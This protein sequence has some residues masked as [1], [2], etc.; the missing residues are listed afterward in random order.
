M[1][2]PDAETSLAARLLAGDRRALSRSLTV[3]ENNAA[4]SGPLLSE[5]FPWTGR[6]SVIGFTGSPGAG[7]STL[8]DRVAE[9]LVSQGSKVAILA[10][11][12]SSPFT[13]GAILG[14]RIRM[15]R[16]SESPSVF[17]RSMASRGALGGLAPRS[18]EFIFALDAAG[19][20]YIL[21]ETVGVGQG[22]VEIVRYCDAVCVVLV[23]GMGDG[24]QALKAGIL[25]IADIFVIN[26]AD[27]DG[28]D[29]LERELIVMLGL[30]QAVSEDSPPIIR[31]VASEGK[32]TLE[33]VS[34]VAKR[35]DR[36][37]QTGKAQERRRFFMK[38]AL[39][40]ESTRLLAMGFETY[41]ETNGLTALSLEELMARKQDPRTAA[42]ELVQEYLTRKARDAS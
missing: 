36:F 24:I 11:D 31:T 29:R 20:D 13:G 1:S 3:I 41:C 38:E 5:I 18:A 23:P 35:L 17:I 28:A 2:A 10:V 8:V 9:Q 14:D 22:E 34:L 21:V 37:R 26:K 16:V 42:Q 12:P 33:F 4:E 6:A 15:S 39:W 30:V 7:K 40:R 32:G 27:Y 25:E 19:F